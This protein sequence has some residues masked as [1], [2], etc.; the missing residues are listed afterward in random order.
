MIRIQRNGYE[1]RLATAKYH[2][3]NRYLTSPA[4]VLEFHQ[5]GGRQML[6]IG[7]K[8]SQQA[9][10]NGWYWHMGVSTARVLFDSLRQIGINPER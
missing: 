5:L 2:P 7:E 4:L 9:I 6:F 10:D 3:A 8:R 1:R